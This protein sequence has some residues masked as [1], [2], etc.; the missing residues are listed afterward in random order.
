MLSLC[1]DFF[2]EIL[3]TIPIYSDRKVAGVFFICNIQIF[4]YN[5]HTY[6]LVE[7]LPS[8]CM[9]VVGI[10]P[11]ISIDCNPIYLQN[12]SRVIYNIIA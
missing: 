8:R 4:K 11:N 3:K 12:L 1:Y 5:I 9:A 6:T 7:Y 10:I 2:R